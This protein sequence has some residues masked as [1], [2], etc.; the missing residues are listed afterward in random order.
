MLLHIK[1]KTTTVSTSING[2]QLLKA[3]SDCKA[4]AKKYMSLT[5][6]HLVVSESDDVLKNTK[7]WLH[8]KDTQE[9]T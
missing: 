4:G 6:E 8:V 3:V 7:G 1:N 9:S 2:A 5:L